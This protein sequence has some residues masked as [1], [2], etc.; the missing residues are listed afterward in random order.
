MSIP[1]TPWSAIQNFNQKPMQR[2]ARKRARQESR[3][4]L[5]HVLQMLKHMA[6]LGRHWYFEWP[7]RCQGWQLPELAAF[8]SH[9]I[10]KGCPVYEVRIDG[11]R[12]GLKSQR[13]PCTYVKKAWT[14][15]TTDHTFS[16]S[17]GRRCQGS[18]HPHTVIRGRDTNHS[19]F[20]PRAMGEAVA[21]HW[22]G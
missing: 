22:C 3:L 8:R 14:I 2:R 15:L 21:R 9:C 1:C 17:C 19:A 18:T 7:T 11:C 6:G 12:Y 4:L 20:Y 13:R 5:G 16:S 10:D